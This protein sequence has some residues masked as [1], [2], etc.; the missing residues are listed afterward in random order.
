[1]FAAHS[2]E[3]VYVR[4]CCHSNETD[5][6]IEKL[7]QYAKRTRGYPLPFPKGTLGCVQ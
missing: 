1:M 4:L 6:Q 3:N 2:I 5:A 7:L